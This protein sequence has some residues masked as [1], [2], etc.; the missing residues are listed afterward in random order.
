M[1]RPPLI[2]PRLIFIQPIGACVDAIMAFGV[3]VINDQPV[4]WLFR[5]EQPQVEVAG[6]FLDRLQ[7]AILRDC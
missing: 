2:H 5:S 6:R 4:I 7:V 1:R 3:F